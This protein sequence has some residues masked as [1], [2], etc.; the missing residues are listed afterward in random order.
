[1][2][3]KKTLAV[4]GVSL[5]SL[6]LAACGGGGGTADP[7]GQSSASGSAGGG[8]VV[9]GSAAFTESTVV[10]ELYAQALESH[11]YTI[12]RQL[13]IGQREVYVSEIES[14]AIDIFPEY[15]GNFLQY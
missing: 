6:L 12:D 2:T 8:A 13:R 14:G 5:A 15:A 9:V 11:G 10:A 1:M 7:L 3:F 4:A